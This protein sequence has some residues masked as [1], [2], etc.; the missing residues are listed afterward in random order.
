MDYGVESVQIALDDVAD[1]FADGG[2]YD[3][4]VSEGAPFVVVGI[5]ARDRMPGSRED[6]NHHR[7]DVPVVPGQEYPHLFPLESVKC[8]REGEGSNQQS[9]AIQTLF[10]RGSRLNSI[11]YRSMR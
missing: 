1:V 6:A 10:S 8:G 9:K 5:E 11:V 4:G 2:H 3:G 7:P